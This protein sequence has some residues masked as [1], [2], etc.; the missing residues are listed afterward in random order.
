VSALDEIGGGHME[1]NM[2]SSGDAPRSI[3]P[4]APLM[5]QWR[6]GVLHV[7]Q[8]IPQMPGTPIGLLQVTKSQKHPQKHKR[9]KEF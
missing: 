6:C 5:P 7:P 2:P 8:D 3:I 4:V 9:I 1:L